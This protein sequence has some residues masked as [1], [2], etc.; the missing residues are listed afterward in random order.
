MS[1]SRVKPSFVRRGRPQDRLREFLVP[2]TDEEYAIVATEALALG[3][4]VDDYIL[5]RALDAEAVKGHA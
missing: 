1:A 2:F 5:L 4:T 3:L